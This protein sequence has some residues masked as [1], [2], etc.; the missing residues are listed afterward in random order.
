MLYIPTQ[1][2]HR[3]RTLEAGS[4]LSVLSDRAYDREKYYKEGFPAYL[5]SFKGHA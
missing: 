4:S 5:A 3:V 2:W 1:V